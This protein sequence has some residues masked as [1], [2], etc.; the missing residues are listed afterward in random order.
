MRVTTGLGSVFILLPGA[1][2]R[3]LL[4]LAA[5]SGPPQKNVYFE[6]TGGLTPPGARPQHLPP[7]CPPKPPWRKTRNKYWLGSVLIDS[8]PT[9]ISF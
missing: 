4:P 7:G 2:P 1:R 8:D 6:L 3:N 9:E 5:P